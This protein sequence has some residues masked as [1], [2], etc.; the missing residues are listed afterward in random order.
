MSGLF[1]SPPSPHPPPG[2]LSGLAWDSPTSL[3]PCQPR[4]D[5]PPWAPLPLPRLHQGPCPSSGP[6][7]CPQPG[8]EVEA[9]ES[10]LSLRPG[11]PC[12]QPGSRRPTLRAATGW[13]CRGACG[14]YRHLHAPRQPQTPW[15]RPCLAI[16]LQPRRQHSSPSAARLVGAG[17]SCW[18]ARARVP[19]WALL[20]HPPPCSPPAS[21][22]QPSHRQHSRQ[23]R[24]P[25]VLSRRSGGRSGTRG[26]AILSG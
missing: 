20:A 6:P 21:G 11:R 1:R 16:S 2:H 10:R 24:A 5:A 14:Y 18:Q 17:G 19:Q 13:A 3:V 26:Q 9:S 22:E 25:W 15:P 8:Q 4:Q 23:T 12:W 7:G